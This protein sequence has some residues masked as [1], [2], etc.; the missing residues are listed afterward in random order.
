MFRSDISA[1]FFATTALIGSSNR[2]A[3]GSNFS[4]GATPS[5]TSLTAFLTMALN[6]FDPA[7]P[8]FRLR[9]P[10]FAVAFLG[11]S[12]AVSLSISVSAIKRSISASLNMLDSAFVIGTSTM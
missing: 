6:R 11:A 9:G 5:K 2:T 8:R 1:L 10:L 12:A 7:A 3:A 4:E